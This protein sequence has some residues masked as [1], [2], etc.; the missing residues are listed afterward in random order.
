MKSN[1]LNANQFIRRSYILYQNALN[2]KSLCDK[3]K[4]INDDFITT[5]NEIGDAIELL[6]KGIAYYFNNQFEVTHGYLDIINGDIVGKLKNNYK[7]EF[8]LKTDISKKSF[9]E[10]RLLHEAKYAD[11]STILSNNKIKRGLYKDFYKKLKYEDLDETF[12][13]YNDVKNIFIKIILIDKNKYNNRIKNQIPDLFASVKLNKIFL[14]SYFEEHVFKT[15]K[16]FINKKELEEEKILLK[17]KI[18][19]YFI[20]I[21]GFIIDWITFLYNDYDNKEDSG[22]TRSNSVKENFNLF[23]SENDGYFTYFEE[24]MFFKSIFDVNF[25]MYN[26]F[27]FKSSLDIKEDIDHYYDFAIKFNEFCENSVV[28][29]SELL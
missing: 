5:I 24:L 13:Y 11:D 6:L 12:E 14:D 17:N 16:S 23:I 22:N 1:E 2:M 8:I 10:G 28:Y 21:E 20:S 3:Q 27:N 26:Y 29:I 19:T 9:L 7:K 25:D 15:N 4:G 18:W